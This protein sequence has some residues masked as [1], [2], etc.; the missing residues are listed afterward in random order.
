MNYIF[1][2][3][4]IINFQCLRD[5]MELDTGTVL[6]ELKTDKYTVKLKVVDE[7]HVLYNDNPEGLADE[8]KVYTRPSAFPK[9]L[10]RI[11]SEGLD[12]EE[13]KNLRIEESNRFELRVYLSDERIPENER[14]TGFGDGVIPEDFKTETIL[15]YLIQTLEYYERGE[16]GITA[17][18]GSTILAEEEFD[19]KW[20][21]VDKDD[22]DDDDL[23]NFIEDCYAMYETA[24][25]LDTIHPVYTE[26]G[27]ENYGQK[28]EVIRRAHFDETDIE[29]MPLWLVLFAN[30]NTAYCY[31]EEIT[32]TEEKN[33]NASHKLTLQEVRELIKSRGE[34]NCSC[35]EQFEEQARNYVQTHPES[36]DKKIWIDPDNSFY[37]E[38]ESQHGVACIGDVVAIHFDNKGRMRFDVSTE[39]DLFQDVLS[40]EDSKRGFYLDDWPDALRVLLEHLEEPYEPED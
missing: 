23:L 5:S 25:F 39:F 20:K 32:A 16:S 19:K 2:L 11:F 36:K 15:H 27:E 9:S 40:R 26:P 30:G 35:K 14:W 6:A 12:T 17:P 4:D 31:P 22:L 3:N 1:T 24:G 29:S 7:V 33:R 38:F 37:C 13:M 34:V 28:F 8:G 10:K 21:D 18:V